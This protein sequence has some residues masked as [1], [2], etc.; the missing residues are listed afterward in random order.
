MKIHEFSH[1]SQPWC[2]MQKAEKGGRNVKKSDA[3]YSATHF[4]F[5]AFCDRFRVFCDKCIAGLWLC[6]RIPTLVQNA[7]KVTWNTLLYTFCFSHFAPIFT[8]IAHLKGSLPFHLLFSP[9]FPF[10]ILYM[11]CGV[12][13]MDIYTFKLL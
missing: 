9:V 11:L 8:Y 3:R 5:F 13:Q 2:Q 1:E 6:V 12:L 7:E 10:K 4:L